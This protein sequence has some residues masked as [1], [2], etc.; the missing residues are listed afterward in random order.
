MDSKIIAIIAVVAVVAAGVG[1][2]VVTDIGDDDSSSTAGMHFTDAVGRDVVAPDNLKN[3]IVA[4]G[5]IGPLRILSMFD[6]AEK[7]IECD[8]GDVT[9]SKNG[10]AY[11]YAW[12]YD[13]L[14]SYHDDNKL[15]SATVEKIAEKH[16]SLVIVGNNIW[17]NYQTNVEL[18]AKACT[19]I[20]L[21]NQT[22]ATMW[23]DNNKLEATLRD[24]I[25]LVGNMVNE[26]SRADKVIKGIEDIMDD[27]RAHTGTSDKYVYVAGV[28]ISGS[29]T[30]NTTFPT[31]LPFKLI[32]AKNAY[33]GGSTSSKVTIPV[34][35][36]SDASVIHS[37]DLIVIDPSSS[38]K[39]K[40]LDSQNSLK[41]FFDNAPSTPMYIT[42]PIVWDSI[43]YDCALASAYYIEAL[44]YGTLSVDE[45]KEKINNIFKVFYGKEH[46]KKVYDSMVTFFEG[47]SSTNGVEFPLLSQVHIV[48]ENSK[49]TVKA[50]AA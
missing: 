17:T 11:S 42:M 6:A 31:Y 29:N 32:G 19:V 18:L 45:V 49:Y 12:D 28:T 9:D 24:N 46:G 35:S 20:V 14:T 27:I 43:N 48:Y 4:V 37:P 47:K 8:K 30:F 10:R 22:M 36:F 21:Y 50:G 15:E 16:P 39:I 41:Y 23:D 40:E 44:L 26:S 13:K 33:V 38:D 5:S 2:Y 1:I 3:G 34:E 25:K 7:V